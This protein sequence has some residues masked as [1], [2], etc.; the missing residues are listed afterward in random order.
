[1]SPAWADAAIARL[2]DAHSCPV[3]ESAWLV[4]GGCPACGADL[5]GEPGARLWS[6]SVAAAEALR[7]RESLL[8]RV[9]RR[10]PVPAVAGPV[11]VP[12]AGAVPIP[13]VGTVP[14]TA[15][16]SHIAP[17][18]PTHAGIP[19]PDAV[20]PSE[21]SDS[22]SLQSVL[23]IA[24]AALFA[25]AAIVFTFFNPELADRT[26]RSTI[27]GGV[28]LVF[29]GG[30]WLLARRRLQSSAEAV[31]GLGL[32]F[33]GLDVQAIGGSF[34]DGGSAWVAA[35]IATA[36]A[37]GAMLVAALRAGIRI[38]LWTSLLALAAS[39]AMLGFA[40]G[41]AAAALWLAASAF[42]ATGLMTLLPRFAARFPG[43]DVRFP[44]GAEATDAGITGVA[45]PG[46]LA[47]PAPGRRLGAELVALTVLQLIVTML[48]LPRVL[49]SGAEP[50]VV[51]GVL[52][53]LA[54]H[55]VLAAVRT[56]T[57]VWSFTAGVL[58]VA[59]ATAAA[60]Q[61]ATAAAWTNAVLPAG[62]VLALL[63]CAL[64]PLPK[65]TARIPLVV[66]AGLA[67][68]VTSAPAVLSGALVGVALL[69][70]AG[71]NAGIPGG[72]AGF[73]PVLGSVAATWSTILALAVISAGFA[74][75]T[76]CIRRRH[77]LR[78]LRTAALIVAALYAIAAVL[79][80]SSA[81]LLPRPLSIAVLLAAVAATALALMGTRG[82]GAASV[83]GIL[84]VGG[85]LALLVA[86]MLA[87]QDRALV[88]IAGIA[89]LLALAVV[90]G[91]MPAAVRFLHVGVGYGYAL[92]LVGT[93]LSLAGVGGIA[94]LCLTASAGL[95]G[96][97][98]ATF[99]PW[100]GARNWQAVLVVA[101]VPFAI[102]IV[103]VVFER[104]GW[105]ALSTGLM[106]VLALVLLVTRRAGLTIVIRTL[107]AA[108]LVPALAVVILCLGAQLLVQSGS[109]VVLP[110]IAIVVALV[111]P[112]GRMIR[113]ALV[114]HGRIAA[115]ADAARVAIEASALLTGSIAVLLSLVRAA[116][117]FGTAC[118]VL[119]LLGIGAALTSLLAGRRY[120]WWVSGVAFTGALWSLWALNGVQLPEAYLLPPALGAALIA[121]L[122]TLRGA[123]AVPL[124]ATGL[125]AAVV[126]VLL[127][128]IAGDATAATPW[129]AHGLLACGWLLLGIAAVMLRSSRP[130][131]R[132]LRP[133]RAAT[134]IAAGVAALGGT[135]QAARWGSGLDAAPV[136]GGEAGLFL[137]SVG[138]SAVAAL[139]LL[140]AARMLRPSA[141]V[142]SA[143]A[144]MLPVRW[145][146]VPA[147]LAF[148][149]GV[150]PAIARD[151]FVIWGMW[152]LM[153]CWLVVMVLAARGSL[154]P[155][156]RSGMTPPVW[157]LFGIAFVTA[158]V[159]WSPRELRV[160]MFS[161]PLGLF[162][163]A[164]GALG[165]R[166]GTD[167]EQQPARLDD[168][169]RGR[170]GSWALLAP[171]LLAMMSA[172]VVST[173]T[174]PLTWRAILVMALALAAILLGAARRLAAPFVI[175][176]IALPVENVFVF[177][178][179]LGRGIES[180]PWWITLA[181]V[182]AVLLII[183]VAGE[184]REG[185]GRGVMAR[186]RD[187]R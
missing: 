76:L 7:R 117:G 36:A 154:R 20:S 96:A 176:L 165:I 99:A 40:F 16:R 55:A 82:R 163:L 21:S 79:C 139:A 68:G 114:A 78:V 51:A 29:L 182:G 118:L 187:L 102:G 136:R 120:G 171:G 89:T 94:L 25:V 24:G 147:A 113:D 31:G 106:F 161:L 181:T 111:L 86:V 58:A 70:A 11:P 84:I 116:A 80:L 156:D 126:P 138:L 49:F 46:V 12:V 128:L 44:A 13:V 142:S 33:L 123:R 91:T 162:L 6:A 1:M 119:I 104:S 121:G 71:A 61:T 98:G 34:L 59:A 2:H 65:R 73:S 140:A 93:A 149:I 115:T 47:D 95:L 157:V 124:F 45:G 8:S 185:T 90:A 107:A 152:T 22:T 180:M 3:C 134:V 97:V 110:L 15:V 105:T 179:Q 148:A 88:P 172:S 48:S 131:P 50:I 153:M 87:W 42:A 85:H 56:I 143:L 72:A 112:S 67:A 137:L 28:T 69:N 144:R 32:V 183:A 92:M 38:W 39:P 130:W 53:V 169:P 170:R 184:R 151:W 109:P 101:A 108:V 175:G 158:V 174:D 62:A 27:I 75:F 30:A 19:A 41:G 37:G 5:T 17:E 103:Q 186:M 141:S 43:G 23:A 168:W 54:V 63:L 10:M 159:A 127:L 52:A 35:A 150:W 83:R 74:A 173:F 100:L 164:A 129:R 146:A 177:A 125:A 66:G 64:V 135:V 122:L 18:T 57:P 133:L 160:E 132:R 9:P 14:G 178:V 26:V 60:M 155:G 145:L 167:A 77:E 4:N 166:A 81:Q